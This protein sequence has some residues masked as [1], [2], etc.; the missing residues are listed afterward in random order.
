M[1]H[2]HTQ[3]STLFARAVSYIVASYNECFVTAVANNSCIP[4]CD[5]FLLTLKKKCFYWLLVKWH[6][7][8]IIFA[9]R[10]IKIL[11]SFFFFFFFSFAQ[12]VLSS[13][14]ETCKISHSFISCSLSSEILRNVRRFIFTYLG[15][16]FYYLLYTSWQIVRIEREKNLSLLT[17]IIHRD[18][19]P[20]KPISFDF[21]LFFRLRSFDKYVRQVGIRSR[22]KQ[23]CI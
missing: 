11:T 6:F 20:N 17:S 14:G 23:I 8:V 3:S 21:L 5:N 9:P 2:L 16:N 12:G 10:R 19:Q 4:L 7:T 1:A 13:K 22:S 15:E 18:K